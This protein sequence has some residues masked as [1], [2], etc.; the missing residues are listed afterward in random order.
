MLGKRFLVS[1]FRAKIL[2][3]LS[4]A[5]FC[6]L[7]PLAGEAAFEWR[8]VG[9]RPLGMGGAYVSLS[10]GAETLFWNPAG[11]WK[12]QAS[13][14]SSYSRPF[15]LGDL[16]TSTL[17]FLLPTSVGN[18]GLGAMVYGLTLYRETSLMFS[19][20]NAPFQYLSFG[21]NLR[22]LNLS[23][24][25]FG[26][27][28]TAAF[29]LGTVLYISENVRWGASLWNVNRAKIV[30]NGQSVP[31]SFS[32]GLSLEPMPGLVLSVDGRKDADFP[33]QIRAGSEHK[34]SDVF[35]VRTG[36][37]GGEPSRF[38]LGTGFNVKRIK[39]DYSFH[40]HP[41]LG[42]SH[43]FSMSGTLK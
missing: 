33:F 24:E 3:V 1:S 28:W 38:S 11:L 34:V 20:S 23:L 27:T 41:A 22:G 32:T 8:G 4:L 15:G 36:V 30:Q 26:S 14:F 12:S 18:I 39:I 2:L 9:S 13:W 31:R 40:T 19:Y 21:F 16:S 42:L 37:T 6:A 43:H 5:G 10:G 7:Q 29:D 35:F 17:A 25:G